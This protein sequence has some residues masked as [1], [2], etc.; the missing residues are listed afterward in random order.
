MNQKKNGLAERSAKEL[1]DDYSSYNQRLWL[2]KSEIYDFFMTINTIGYLPLVMHRTMTEMMELC[3]GKKV[4]DL[5]TGTG[6][7]LRS[8]GVVCKET[9][10]K[11]FVVALDMS[12]EMMQKARIKSRKKKLDVDFVQSDATMSSFRDESFD[13]VC[14]SL[15]LHDMPSELIEKVVKEVHRILKKGGMFIS[16]EISKPE[17]SK[18]IQF[19]MSLHLLF[20]SYYAKKNWEMN[21]G[22][23]LAQKDFVN[24]SRRVMAFHTFQLVRAFKPA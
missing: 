21:F 2:N 7:Q 17:Y 18:L 8:I 4:L 19:L 3:D 1:M 22:E 12:L 24:I 13:V 14:C 20:D 23:Y 5:C 9:R 16:L 6:G 15:A 11:P 10:V